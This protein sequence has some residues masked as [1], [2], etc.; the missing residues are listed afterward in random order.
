M[1]N[2]LVQARR[3]YLAYASSEEVI[4]KLLDNLRQLRVLGVGHGSVVVIHWVDSVQTA[5]GE[6][7]ASTLGVRTTPTV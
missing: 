1:Q 6:G 3:S 7:G 2:P 4:F 5:K